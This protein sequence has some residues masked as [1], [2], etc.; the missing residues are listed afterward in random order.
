MV[1]LEL[2]FAVFRLLLAVTTLSWMLGGEV[3]FPPG[4]SAVLVWIVV[5]TFC[6]YTLLVYVYTRQRPELAGRIDSLTAVIDASFVTFMVLLTPEGPIA[7]PFRLCYIAVVALHAF[8]FGLGF[9]VPLALV[10][11]ALYVAA[12]VYHESPVEDWLLQ[13]GFPIVLMV[14]VGFCSGVL[15]WREHDR[16]Q[17]LER[18]IDDLER[19]VDNA[20]RTSAMVNQ[21]VFELYS[22][23]HINPTG[24]MSAQLRDVLESAFEAARGVLGIDAYAL[25]L[26]DEQTRRLRVVAA[27]G[28]PR[29]LVFAARPHADEGVCARVLASPE[30]KHFAPAAEQITEIYGEPVPE[31][32]GALLSVPLSVRGAVVGI[33]NFHRGSERRF[34][35]PEIALL[36]TIA[37]HVALSMGA[38]TFYQ[39]V[40][41]SDA[42]DTESGL[43]RREHLEERLRDEWR[44]AAQSG[45]PISLVLLGVRGLMNLPA[46][47]EGPRARLVREVGGVLIHLS[48]RTD[49]AARFDE[50][51]FALL[52]SGASMDVAGEA[53]NRLR[54]RVEEVVRSNE[55]WREAVE[56]VAI[57]VSGYPD[58]ATEPEELVSRA[59]GALV[60]ALQREEP[61]PGRRAPGG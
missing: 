43:F 53:G 31:V 42:A 41:A 11:G 6:L 57:G 36:D 29:R 22:L 2:V 47:E 14:V 54:E 30:P 35:P 37:R 4:W 23:Y 28:L 12:C 39:Q 58:N 33:V 17:R 50:E 20:E 49:I 55:E 15:H 27:Q 26:I 18:A 56:A 51:T 7:S 5:A 3:R 48:R 16:H 59:R 1:S 34:R 24:G 8:Y 19:R 38:A 32:S 46:G 44:A 40:R 61:G 10:C 25:L 13:V 21:R 60:R 52:M 9:G 45:I